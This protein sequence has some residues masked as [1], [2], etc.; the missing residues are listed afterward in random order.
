MLGK[1]AKYQNYSFELTVGGPDWSSAI[2]NRNFAAVSSNQKGMIG[3][4]YDHAMFD[5]FLDRIL[6][7]LAGV[8]VNDLKYLFDRSTQS[9]LRLPARYVGGNLI[10]ERDST[11]GISNH[12]AIADAGQGRAEQVA[13]LLSL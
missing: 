7:R 12:D 6:H 10:H 9:I 2:V 1:V 11:G 3:Q 13:L 5:Y 8:L 4:A